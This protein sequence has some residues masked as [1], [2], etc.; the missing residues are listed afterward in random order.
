MSCPALYA[1]LAALK[2]NTECEIKQLYV[3]T[4]ALIILWTK[5]RELRP[6]WELFMHICAYLFLMQLTSRRF[7]SSSHSLKYDVTATL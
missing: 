7:M 1:W 5:S 6:E 4:C 2:L 3:K